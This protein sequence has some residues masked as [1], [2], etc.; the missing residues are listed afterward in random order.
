MRNN[1]KK[2]L[3]SQIKNIEV[4]ENFLNADEKSLK[5]SKNHP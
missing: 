4:V 5:S 3:K 2:W 1:K